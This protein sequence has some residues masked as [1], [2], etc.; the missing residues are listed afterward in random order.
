M[1]WTLRYA[2]HLSL[3][4]AMALVIC[5]AMAARLGFQVSELRAERAT[6]AA[7]ERR[8][9]E[10]ATPRAPAGLQALVAGPA[11]SLDA[12][13]SEQLNASFSELGLSI[14]N[15]E[16]VSR[17]P[18]GAGLDSHF[19]TV[20]ARGDAAA[21]AK[22]MAWLEANQKAIA[23]EQATAFAGDSPAAEW[24]FKLIVLVARTDPPAAEAR[25]P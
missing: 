17:R 4:A 5:A 21:G 23:V 19:I 9:A 1:S 13:V 22:A 6:L 11:R 10:L 7:G 25:Q 16:T 18:F 20:R 3:V 2:T 15:A 24:T 8:V 14:T 12:K